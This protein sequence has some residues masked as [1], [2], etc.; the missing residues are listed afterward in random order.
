[1]LFSAS[2]LVNMATLD[3]SR[4][5]VNEAF[6]MEHR[7]TGTDPSQERRSTTPPGHSQEASTSTPNAARNNGTPAKQNP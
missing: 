4:G 1:M 2:A 6:E 5:H 3:S 7:S